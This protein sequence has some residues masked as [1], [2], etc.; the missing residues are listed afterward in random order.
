V[1]GTGASKD[2]VVVVGHQ[3]IK[4]RE[5]E[6][7]R[8]PNEL[9]VN[10]SWMTIPSGRHRIG[11]RKDCGWI[12]RI[13][14]KPG[15][16]EGR[17][18]AAFPGPGTWVGARV[19][20]PRCP[21]L[22]PGSSSV[23]ETTATWQFRAGSPARKPGQ[24]NSPGIACLDQEDVQGSSPTGGLSPWCGVRRMALLGYHVVVLL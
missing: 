9:S 3:S 22:R 11:I 18:P 12:Y 1:E 10:G 7:M 14:A 16:A 20:S 4:P 13:T 21:I 15:N 23:F 8:K 19:A 5:V 24:R 17:R 2:E 6:A